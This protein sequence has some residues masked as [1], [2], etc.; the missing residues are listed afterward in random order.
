MV[1]YSFKA[2]FAPPIVSLRKSGTIRAHRKRHARPGEQLQ[3][4]TGMRTK[5]C[6]L[7][8][9]SVCLDVLPIVIN[10]PRKS[11]RV[12]SPMGSTFGRSAA[13]LDAFAVADGFADWADMAAFW[14]KEHPGIEVFEGVLIRW[15][16]FVPG[17]EMKEALP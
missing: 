15:H 12:D 16:Q 10:L 17:P 5:S 3:L 8:G 2:R 11:I 13:D 1:A 9:R 4:Y 6:R 14:A 7:I